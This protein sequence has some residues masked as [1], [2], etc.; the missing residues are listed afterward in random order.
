V[1]V[2]SH[3]SAIGKLSDDGRYILLAMRADGFNGAKAA[4]KGMW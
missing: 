3:E 1:K 4:K 2:S